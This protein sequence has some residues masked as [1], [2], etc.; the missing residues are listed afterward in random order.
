[1]TTTL[2]TFYLPGV[3]AAF[4]ALE[5][6]RADAKAAAGETGIAIMTLIVVQPLQPLVG[7]MTLL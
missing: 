6:L 1:M 2:K 4:P 7:F 3:L 5:G